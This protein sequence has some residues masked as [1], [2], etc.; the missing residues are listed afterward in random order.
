MILIDIGNTNI[1]FALSS[2]NMLKKIKRIKTNED[3]KILKTLINKII[4]DYL[5]TNEIDN[6]KV[7]I[8]ASV[9]PNLNSLIKNVLKQNS[10]KGF[11]IRSKDILP[12]LKIRYDLKEIGADRLAN[13]MAIIKNKITNSIVIDFGT[14][15]TFEVI[16][17]N[18]FLGGIIF[19]GI[20]LSKK[21]LIKEASLLKNTEI[22]KTS[23]V[24][25]NNTQKSIQS[26]FYWGYLLAINGLIKKIS[27]E[28]KFKPKII[29]TGGLANIFKNDIK[30]KPIIKPNLTL[31]GL[32][33]IGSIYYAKKK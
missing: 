31:E 23:K 6:Y 20:N 17:N 7:A 5:Y 2:N 28:N 13:S 18:I 33:I 14:A 15:T 32:K 29:L 12:F 26:G 11:I 25:A 16:K 30:P 22:V 9:V 10:I 3:K 27:K 4:G 19:P 24:V 8:I 21:T 1:V